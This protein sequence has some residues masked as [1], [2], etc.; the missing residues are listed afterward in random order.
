MSSTKQPPQTPTEHLMTLP[1]VKAVRQTDRPES[2][3]IVDLGVGA[4]QLSDEIETLRAVGCA[5]MTVS[6]HG[7]YG[8][9][10][11]VTIP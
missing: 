3:H 5:D 8:L 1:W 10:L 6:Q 2:T 11:Y 7:D 9:R 4:V